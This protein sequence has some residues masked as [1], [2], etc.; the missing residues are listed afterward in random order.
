VPLI[1]LA[2]RSTAPALRALGAKG[3]KL[4]GVRAVI[5][6]ASSV[7][8]VESGGWGSPLQFE[9]GQNIECLA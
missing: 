4:L 6:E 1:I 3:P 7:F 9:S 2:G 5:A 8:T